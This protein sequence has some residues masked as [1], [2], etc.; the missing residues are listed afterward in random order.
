MWGPRYAYVG[1][2]RA[3]A[4]YELRDD[5][6]IVAMRPSGCDIVLA[7]RLRDSCHEIQDGFLRRAIAP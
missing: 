6:R 7:A 3:L 2:A 4:A 1:D 5:Q